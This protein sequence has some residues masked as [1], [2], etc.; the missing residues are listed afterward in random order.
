MTAVP[1]DSI[2]TDF[3]LSVWMGEGAEALEASWIYRAG[4]FDNAAI[5]ALWERYVALLEAAVDQPD[6]DRRT[7]TR[8]DGQC[9]RFVESS[10]TRT[11]P[12]LEVE[13]R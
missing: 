10:G 3:D 12:Q 5:R 11:V 9:E 13:S 6:A 4:M 8:Q 7:G 2:D 1:F